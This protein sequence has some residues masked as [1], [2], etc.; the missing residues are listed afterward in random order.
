MA[1]TQASGR[2]LDR[3]QREDLEQALHGRRGEEEGLGQAVVV[4]DVQGQ[5]AA[6]RLE[7]VD[8]ELVDQELDL[9][10]LGVA[11]LGGRL[12]GDLDHLDDVEE[13]EDLR[14]ARADLGLGLGEGIDVGQRAR[15][16]AVGDE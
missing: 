5:R 16:P 1:G 7:A 10:G 12:G 11:P 4:A 3:R 6:D 8:A 14:V 15:A 9:L 2:R 13:P